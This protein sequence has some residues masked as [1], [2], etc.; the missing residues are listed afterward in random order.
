MQNCCSALKVLLLYLL[1]ANKEKRLQECYKKNFTSETTTK[2]NGRNTTLAP[3][4]EIINTTIAENS[5][6]D[7]SISIKVYIPITLFLFL[8]VG[9]IIIGIVCRRP[10]CVR[11]NEQHNGADAV[12][13]DSRGQPNN[14]KNNRSLR[15][16]RNGFHING[17]HGPNGST[18]V[19]F[20]STGVFQDNLPFQNGQNSTAN[21]QLPSEG[22]QRIDE[23]NPVGANISLDNTQVNEGS[24]DEASHQSNE[25]NGGL[26]NG[27]QQQNERAIESQEQDQY[28]N[29][30]VHRVSNRSQ[31]QNNI[32]NTLYC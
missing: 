20:E 30:E 24:L 25:A 27:V 17:S 22:Q 12:L 9:A 13:V 23:D 1:G 16:N 5:V 6:Q 4:I 32:G 18:A 28:Q 7:N 29:D 21:G 15:W 10:F 26:P 11:Q 8:L 31:L 2:F 19:S 14:D 3:S